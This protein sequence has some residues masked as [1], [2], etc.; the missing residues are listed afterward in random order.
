MSEK[1][2]LQEKARNLGLDDSGTIAELEARIA[3]KAPIE[4]NAADAPPAADALEPDPEAAQAVYDAVMDQLEEDRR[5]AIEKTIADRKAAEKQRVKDSVKQM[6]TD[7]P[8]ASPSHEEQRARELAGKESS[9]AASDPR[10]SVFDAAPGKS[11]DDV[12]TRNADLAAGKFT[13]EAEE[14][15]PPQFYVVGDELDLIE[16]A[17]KLGLHDHSELA[18]VNGRYSSILNVQP[19]QRVVLPARYRFDG[20]EGVVTEGEE[21]TELAG[22][23]AT[24]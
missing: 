6:K 12:L 5:K 18:A 16:V 14:K 3:E 17:R 10:G 13:D 11:L 23:E 1:T 4:G 8:S 2:D 9:L 20:I 19:G 15:L 22:A 7:R 21:A 24:A